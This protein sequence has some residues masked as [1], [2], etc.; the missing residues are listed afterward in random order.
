MILNWSVDAYI[1][2]TFHW[3]NK[4]DVAAFTSLESVTWKCEALYIVKARDSEP[5]L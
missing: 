1:Q 4:Y 3:K 2:Y 5:V